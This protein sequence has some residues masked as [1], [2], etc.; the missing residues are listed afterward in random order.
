[1]SDRKQTVSRIWLKVKR[2]YTVNKS[3]H[4]NSQIRELSQWDFKIKMKN[5]LNDPGDGRPHVWTD[6]KISDRGTK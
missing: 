6:K 4:R 3:R 5:T 1:M 2:V